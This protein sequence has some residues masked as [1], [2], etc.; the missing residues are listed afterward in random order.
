MNIG[1]KYT[2]GQVIS[3]LIT[4]GTMYVFKLVLHQVK[5]KS[6]DYASVVK[7]HLFFLLLENKEKVVTWI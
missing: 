4:E 2:V 5:K 6:L 3:T 1:H 7:Y